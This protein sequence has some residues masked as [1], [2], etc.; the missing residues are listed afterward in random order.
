LRDHK[1]IFHVKLTAGKQP[2]LIE[3]GLLVSRVWKPLNE[4]K[5]NEQELPK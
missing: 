2:G 4:E 5:V 3:V 1:W